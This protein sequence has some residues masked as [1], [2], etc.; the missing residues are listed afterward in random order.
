[1][2]CKLTNQPSSL[3]LQELGHKNAT[4]FKPSKDMLV[5]NN[6][7]GKANNAQ[8]FFLQTKK[9]PNNFLIFHFISLRM[10]LTREIKTAASDRYLLA[11]SGIQC[12]KNAIKNSRACEKCLWMLHYYTNN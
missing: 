4:Q 2:N 8:W 6:W 1:M 11:C 9:S 5:F 10:L 3:L 12:R 7:N